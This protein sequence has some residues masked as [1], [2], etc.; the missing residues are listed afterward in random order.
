MPVINEWVVSKGHHSRTSGTMKTRFGWGPFVLGQ[1]LWTPCALTRLKAL[2]TFQAVAAQTVT[3]RL[4]RWKGNPSK[5]EASGMGFKPFSTSKPPQLEGETPSL[6]H[7]FKIRRSRLCHMS[8]SLEV[9]GQ[10]F[11]QYDD[12]AID[13]GQPGVTPGSSNPLGSTGFR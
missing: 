3:I 2:S 11:A 13:P 1:P 7:S 10:Y 5:F 4:S 8:A 9:E 12:S 6:K